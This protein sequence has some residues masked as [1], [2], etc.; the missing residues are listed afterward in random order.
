MCASESN[1]AGDAIAVFA[2]PVERRI[3]LHSE[4][5]LGAADEVVK[6]ARGHFV[7]L[8]GVHER[9]QYFRGSAESCGGRGHRGVAVETLFMP[10]DGVIEGGTPIREATLFCGKIGAF[11]CDVV[12]E[13]HEGVQRSQGIAFRTGEQE[14]RVIEIAVGRTS[15]TVAFGVGV[16]DDYP[17]FGSAL[18]CPQRD[19][20]SLALFRLPVQTNQIRKQRAPKE[21]RLFPFADGWAMVESVVSRRFDGIEYDQT[22]AGEHLEVHAKVSVH[23]LCQRT[24]FC[25]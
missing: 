18:F 3:G 10:G 23:H 19:G 25:E 17:R 12:H 21:K 9:G 5:H 16:V 6:I 11:V 2:Q 13:A 22:A 4:V 7:A 15:D 8:H 20:N 24:A 14:K 1:G